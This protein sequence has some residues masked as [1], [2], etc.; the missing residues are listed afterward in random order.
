MATYYIVADSII[1]SDVQSVLY[2]Y[3]EIQSHCLVFIQ[4]VQRH[5]YDLK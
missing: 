3:R 4:A 2:L 5:I 1:Y